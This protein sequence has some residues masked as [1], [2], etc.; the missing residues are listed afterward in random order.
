[1]SSSA[2][3]AIAQRIAPIGTHELAEYA[4]AIPPYELRGL[5]LGLR[6]LRD[7]LACMN[8]LLF[9]AVEERE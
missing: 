6:K 1:M 8:R 5:V 9:T 7:V 2:K 3:G 4:Y